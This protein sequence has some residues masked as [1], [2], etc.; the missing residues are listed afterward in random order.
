[1]DQAVH[2]DNRFAAFLAALGKQKDQTA[3]REQKA[4]RSLKE[5]IRS[6]SEALETAQAQ[7]DAEVDFDR[8]DSHIYMMQAL[9][10]RLNA[11]FAQ[12]KKE[13]QSLRHQDNA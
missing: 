12:A 8:I 3:Q 11:L 6:A 4:D 13:E 9:E 2:S 5:Q 1:M 10:N 7:F